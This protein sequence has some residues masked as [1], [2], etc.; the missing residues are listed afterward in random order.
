MIN[1]YLNNKEFVEFDDFNLICEDIE[2]K[3][4]SGYF[5][6]RFCIVGEGRCSFFYEI[7]KFSHI[8]KEY[9]FLSL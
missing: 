7:E 5:R 1:K 8:E 3:L 9:K 4:S 2:Y 6:S